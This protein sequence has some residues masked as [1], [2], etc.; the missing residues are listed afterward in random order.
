MA[1]V[2]TENEIVWLMMHRSSYSKSLL[3]TDTQVLHPIFNL[4]IALLQKKISPITTT[5][6]WASEMAIKYKTYW[7]DLITKK[8][9]QQAPTLLHKCFKY[10]WNSIKES[11]KHTKE[12]YFPPTPFHSGQTGGEQ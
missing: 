8:H 4:Q 7:W 1:P 9:G 11:K 2:H 12:V 3:N 6:I 10:S 5:K